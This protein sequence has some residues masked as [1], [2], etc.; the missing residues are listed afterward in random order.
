MEERAPKRLAAVAALVLPPLILI[1]AVDIVIEQF[2]RGL[3]VLAGVKIAIA[4]GWYGLLRTGWSGSWGS[5]SR[6][7]HSRSGR[8]P[9]SQGRPV[10][11]ALVIL[12]GMALTLAATSA[13][14]SLHVPL[15]NA[16][17]PQRPV[18][19]YNPKSGGGKAKKFNLAEEA[20]PEASSRS[21]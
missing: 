6:V 17:P 14:F 3:I 12:G 13:A 7:R 20:A 15:A 1:L 2:P 11:E 10:I 4:A 18:L 9:D 8:R 16:Q 21:S 5:R 19:F